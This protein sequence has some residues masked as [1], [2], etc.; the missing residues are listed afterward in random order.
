MTSCDRRLADDARSGNG[1]PSVPLL[2]LLVDRHHLDVLI[3][4][5][6]VPWSGV[7]LG[8]D[9]CTSVELVFREQNVKW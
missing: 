2:E 1:L 7:R 3:L 4:L 6:V 8:P 5:D 9:D